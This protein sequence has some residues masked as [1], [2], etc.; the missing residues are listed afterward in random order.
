MGRGPVSPAWLSHRLFAQDYS[1]GTLEQL[2]LFSEP[3]AL[4]VMAKVLAFW[5]STGLPVVAVAPAMGLLLDLEQ[6][7]TPVL[8]LSLLLGTPI[9]ALLGAVGA[10]LT[11]GAWRWHVAG[12]AGAAAVRPVL[13]FGAGAVEAE[14]SGGAAAH[15]LLLGGGLAGRSRWRRWRARQRSEFQPIDDVAAPPCGHGGPRKRNLEA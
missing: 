12:P 5:L 8:I 9:L 7:G 6:G 13:I 14:L 3:A 1:D 4:W 2:L 15:L 11:L 10:A